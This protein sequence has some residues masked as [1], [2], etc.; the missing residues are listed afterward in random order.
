MRINIKPITRQFDNINIDIHIMPEDSKAIANVRY[1]GIM[2]YERIEIN[3]SE[4]DAWGYDDSYIY[5]LV[6]TKLGLE[7]A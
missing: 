5:D 2:E 6:L 1:E 7:R 3:G 4:Y